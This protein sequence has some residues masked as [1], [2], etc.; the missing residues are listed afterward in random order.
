MVNGTNMNMNMNMDR[1]TSTAF[2]LIQ[3]ATK[4]LERSQRLL[5]MSRENPRPLPTTAEQLR[6][7]PMA[8]VRRNR[9]MWA[10]YKRGWHDRNRNRM[11]V[12]KRPADVGPPVFKRPADV[13][14]PPAIADRPRSPTPA[15]TAVA[16]VQPKRRRKLPW[17][18]ELKKMLLKYESELK[19]ARQSD[20][21]QGSSTND[22]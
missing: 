9:N 13:G 20:S 17:K 5:L 3:Q 14:P 4:M 11:A 15:P 6:W 2:N 8:E 12:F 19:A 7:M 18:Q 16:T 10:A 1:R 21:Q 22:D